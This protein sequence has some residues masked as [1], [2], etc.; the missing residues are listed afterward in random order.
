M[1]VAFLINRDLTMG[2]DLYVIEANKWNSERDDHI[3]QRIYVDRDSAVAAA[4]ANWTRVQSQLGDMAEFADA[5]LPTKFDVDSVVVRKDY[6][7][8]MG[9]NPTYG[10]IYYVGWDFERLEEIGIDG[11]SMSEL[12]W[13]LDYGLSI[14]FTVIRLSWNPELGTYG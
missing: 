11:D 6:G 13:E 3:L 1:I 8:G 9:S 14:G 4:E 5:Q 7:L 10:R 2:G 12:N